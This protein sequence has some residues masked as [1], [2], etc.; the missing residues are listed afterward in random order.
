MIKYIFLPER[1]GSYYIFAQRIVGID[2]ART[3][4]YATIVVYKGQ[5]RIIEQL[6]EE[7]IDNDV[8]LTNDER[9]IKALR[10]LHNRLGSY[11]KVYV[12]LS[13]SSVLF[14]ELTLP[15]TGLKK[16]KMV[17]PFEVESLLPFSLDQAVIDAIVTREDRTH[18]QTD[19]LVAA[20]K[21][22]YVTHYTEL[23]NQAGITIDKISVDMFELYGLYKSIPSYQNRDQTIALLDMGLSIT[24]LALIIRGQL[25]YIRVLSKGLISVA[26]RLSSVTH[27]GPNESLQ[28]LIRF[29][30]QETENNEYA[31]AAGDALAELIQE[32]AFT[33]QTYMARLKTPE[34]LESLLLT[35]TGADI[36]GITQLLQKIMHV[37]AEVLQAKKIIHNGTVHSKITTIPNSFLVSIATALSSPITEEFNMW[38]ARES[39]QKEQLVTQQVITLGILTLMLIGSFALYSYMRI[40]T[41]RIARNAIQAEAIAALKKAFNLKPTQTGSLEAANKAADNELRKQETA[42]RRL[43]TDYRYSFLRYLTELTHCINR[44]ETELD[45]TSM[46]ITHDWVKLYGSVPDFSHLALLQ[47]QLECPLFK[48][49]PK[50]QD[51]NFKSEPITLYIKKEQ[52]S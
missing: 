20:A 47:H 37:P 19:V 6:L 5:Q 40:R 26:K 38:R 35:G 15:F 49:L 44:K 10:A 4:I 36:P 33:I 48:K 12:A 46:V 23:F 29:G 18:K 31:Q 34:Q 30:T 41:L 7:P 3:E 43:S 42:W 52:E 25:T 13:S 17:I 45:L 14:K 1:I 32:V 21:R 11:T 51:P 16:V 24:R 28:Q 8:A 39:R 2:I 9:I 27:L 50:L 22:E